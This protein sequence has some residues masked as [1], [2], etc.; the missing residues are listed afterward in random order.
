MTITEQNNPKSSTPS[1]REVNPLTT[2]PTGIRT[3]FS[4][5][6]STYLLN[7]ARKLAGSELCVFIF[8]TTAT[9]L[10]GRQ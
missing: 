1:A 7:L 10:L 2:I 8:L 5:P 3:A 6:I 4:P 9:A